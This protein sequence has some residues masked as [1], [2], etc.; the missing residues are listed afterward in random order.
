MMTPR[1]ASHSLVAFSISV[2]STGWRSNVDR[3]I[4]LSTSL[5][6]VC[7]SSA[8][9]NSRFRAS[10]SV[11]SRTFSIAMTAW[12]AKVSRSAI[13]LSENGRGS[14]RRIT[15]VP[16]ASPSRSSGIARIARWPPLLENALD[17]AS[18]ASG[19]IA[20]S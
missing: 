20:M 4:T 5:V 15:M 7:C 3:L 17:I 13:C 16:S 9:V 18:S 19:S 14:R 1:A 2:S 12:A 10:S 8:S 6:A 11:N